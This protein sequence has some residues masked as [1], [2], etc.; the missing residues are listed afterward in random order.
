VQG[1]PELVL[2][3]RPVDAGLP[4]PPSPLAAAERRVP[5]NGNKCGPGVVA[6][7]YGVK[8]ASVKYQVS[9]TSCGH[10]LKWG[11]YRE[12]PTAAAVSNAVRDELLGRNYGTRNPYAAKFTGDIKAVRMLVDETQARGY[13]GVHAVTNGVAHVAKTRFCGCEL[14]SLEYS[15]EHKAGAVYDEMRRFVERYDPSAPF[16]TKNMFEHR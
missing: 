7:P 10:T 12:L 14:V 13:T 11:T 5:I 3:H 2:A 16:R 9:F 15:S 8:N 1:P 4:P 6:V